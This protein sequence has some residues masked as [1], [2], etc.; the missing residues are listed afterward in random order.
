M[1]PLRRPGCKQVHSIEN[2]CRG[3][4]P[5]RMV[6]SAPNM[7]RCLS[8]WRRRDFRTRTLSDQGRPA[9]RPAPATGRRGHSGLRRNAFAV[10]SSMTAA[11]AVSRK[12]DT[13]HTTGRQAGWHRR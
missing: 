7:E 13:V 3:H 12:L 5:A 11:V 4:G 1:L 8:S 6:S 10:L 2:E 9:R